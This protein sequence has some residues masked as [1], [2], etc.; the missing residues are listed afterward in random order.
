MVYHSAFGYFASEYNLL[1]MP[2]EE[3]GKEPTAAGLARLIAQA[4]EHGIKVIFAE[5]QFNPRSAEVI[6]EAI[7]GR[8]VFIDDLAK[9][10]LTNLRHL[11]GELVQV[12][13]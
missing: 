2:I 13:E 11:L 1:M 5:P 8:V 4:K 10:Y 3:G 9:D 6:A 12:M 7:G